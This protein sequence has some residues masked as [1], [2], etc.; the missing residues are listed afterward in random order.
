MKG[1]SLRIELEKYLNNGWEMVQTV[2]SKIL[3]RKRV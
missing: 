1:W 2:N 3:I